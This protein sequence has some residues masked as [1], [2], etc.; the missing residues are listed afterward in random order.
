MSESSPNISQNI[1][2]SRCVTILKVKE[3]D[4]GVEGK[5]GDK[6]IG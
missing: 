6:G 5:E 3:G 4:K 1:F 2:L